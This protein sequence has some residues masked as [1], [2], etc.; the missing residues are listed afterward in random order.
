M[1]PGNPG[2]GASANAKTP[3]AR[4][5]VTLDLA[6]AAAYPEAVL[7][8]MKQHIEDIEKQERERKPVGQ[9]IDAARKRVREAE[10]ACERADDA[11]A[12]AQ[13]A[14][15][16]AADAVAAAQTA[17]EQCMSEA[18]VEPTPAEA[19]DRDLLMASA[20]HN[21]LV[22]TET[23]W[24]LHAGGPPDRLVQALQAGAQALA[25][26]R[27]TTPPR[28]PTA[29]VA[30]VE[31]ADLDSSRAETETKSFEQLETELKET[32]NAFADALKHGHKEAGDPMRVRILADIS[33]RVVIARQLQFSPGSPP[34]QLLRRTWMRG[35]HRTKHTGGLW[36]ES[37]L[38][39]RRRLHNRGFL[40]HRLLRPR[41]NDFRALSLYCEAE[42]VGATDGPQHCTDLY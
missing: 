30:A 24:P 25:R 8:T 16:R 40:V 31:D 4:A 41:G 18:A 33:E 20:L 29:P 1:R 12:T 35:L 36:G 21:I 32:Q 13:A 26:Q 2:G 15:S 38:R 7:T 11:I 19:E 22:A 9:R 42:S 39:Q 28:S 10:A 17:L 34:A 3:L 27:S 6:I 37:L 23:T 14:R 5:R